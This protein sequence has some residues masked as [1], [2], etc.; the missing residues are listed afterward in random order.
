MCRKGRTGTRAQ[1]APKHHTSTQAVFALVCV[2]A[3][4][5]IDRANHSYYVRAAL[6]CVWAPASI[7]EAAHGGRG[8]PRELARKSHQT[9][10]VSFGWRLSF[11]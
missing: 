8:S 7:D 3:L 1:R 2:W 4:A 9:F 11:M 6:V 10:G 5:S